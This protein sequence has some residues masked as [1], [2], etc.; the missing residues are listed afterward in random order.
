[1]NNRF[2][3]FSYQSI[4]TLLFQSI[5]PNPE[6]QTNKQQ[7]SYEEGRK[8]NILRVKTK[9]SIFWYSSQRKKKRKRSS[10]GKCLVFFEL[11][12]IYKRMRYFLLGIR[13]SVLLHFS[14]PFPL[15]EKTFHISCCKAIGSCYSKVWN[16]ELEYFII[17]NTFLFYLFLEKE[18]SFFETFF[19]HKINIYYGKLIIT[20]NSK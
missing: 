9:Y 14:F 11:F 12:N 1:M 17:G 10:S 18:E 7:L 20:N 16:I 8:D 13:V 4:L 5:T 15:K 3:V 2:Y 6:W 19:A